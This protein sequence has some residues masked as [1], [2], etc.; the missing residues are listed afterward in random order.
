MLGYILTEKISV[1]WESSYTYIY[2]IFADAKKGTTYVTFFL[3]VKML[4]NFL[5]KVSF[6]FLGKYFLGNPKTFYRTNG[7]V[8]RYT[9]F[10][11]AFWAWNF[12]MYRKMF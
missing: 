9:F 7:P 3:L 4:S 1:R 2:C 11:P 10:A 8:V 12:A 6:F 5:S